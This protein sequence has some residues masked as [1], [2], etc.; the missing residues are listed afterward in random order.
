VPFENEQRVLGKDGKYRWFLVRYNP[1]LDAQGKIDRW[2]VAAFDIDDRKRTEWLREAEMRILQMIADGASLTD[3]LNHVCTSV[4]A[5]VSPR[6]TSILLMDSDGKRLWPTAGPKVPEDWARAITPLPVAADTGL[7]GTAAFLKTRVIVP[8]VAAEP[9]WLEEYRGPALKNGI[10]AG[11]SQPILTKDNQVLGTFPVYSGEPRVPTSEDLALIEAA[12]RI[13]LIAIER[14]RS[15]VALRN[16]LEQVQKSESNLR[17]VIDAM[18]ALAWCNLPDGSNEFLNRR[19]HQYTGFS[20]EQ[21]HGWGWQAAFHPEDLP[22][23]MEKWRKMLASGESDEI[24]ARLRR[25]DGVYRWFLIRAEPFRN[26]SGKIV[27]W[28]GTSTDIDDRKRAE[29][30][31]EQSY[32]RLAE[33]QRLSKTGS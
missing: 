3:I 25:H 13:A 18:P 10:R 28:Y 7:C 8:D 30:Q 11:W 19:W 14:Q 23:L 15:Q 27:E 16:A 5:Q 31:V 22:P 29:A 33:A 6:F 4:D 20:P 17:Q 2:Y 24:E 9:I 12:G 1:L 26:E 32:L 21:S